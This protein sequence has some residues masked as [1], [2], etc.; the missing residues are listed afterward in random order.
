MH[1]A[2]PK[3]AD[4]LMALPI[5][6]ESFLLRRSGKHVLVDGGYKGDKIARV[7][8]NQI[9]DVPFLD[10][11]VCT[12]GDS[13]HVGGLPP[14]LKEWSGRIGQMWLP[15]RWVNVAPQLVVD[16]AEFFKQLICELDVE[17]KEPSEDVTSIIR[18]IEGATGQ[19]DV[20][21]D[22]DVSSSDHDTR[23]IDEWVYGT[24][25]PFDKIEKKQEPEWFD[26][27]RRSDLVSSETA[28]SAVASARRK[29]RYRLNKGTSGMNVR[30][31]EY[32]LGLIET[33]E[34]IRKVAIE[35]IEQKIP[36]RWF[37]FEGFSLTRCA[38]GGVPGFFIPV[39]AVEQATPPTVLAKFLQLTKINRE[40]L[41]FLAPPM[42]ERLGV[43]FCADSPLG[44]GPNF[45]NSFLRPL[46]FP[47][48]WFPI[49]AT[50]PHHGS[51]SNKAAYNHLR[52]WMDV[53]VLLR[54]GGS[55][56]QPGATFLGQRDCLR[57]CTKC[58]RAGHAPLL[59]GVVL[60]RSKWPPRQLW[61]LPL[62]IAIGR[63]C[64]C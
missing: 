2:L 30:I 55:T 21:K 42:K 63:R 41:V 48:S 22:T 36:T 54:A 13:D 4:M 46:P 6:G 7:L 59:S 61:H 9:Q 60:N 39:N 38:K 1:S 18:E 57:L 27:L 8:E 15:G 12:H 35:A 53:A 31:A 34:A 5:R 64:V 23:P 17:L 50:A 51:E 3:Q 16:P 43:L 32:W 62:L 44:D 25:L 19:W 56:K 26:K 52:N 37:D 10:V 33:A 24:D 14:L 40:S 45:G 58:P 29:A 28:S 49:V 11:V 47:N 20:W